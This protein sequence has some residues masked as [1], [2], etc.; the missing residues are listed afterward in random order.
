MAKQDL[1]QLLEQAAQ[2]LEKGGDLSQIEADQNGKTKEQKTSKKESINAQIK[3]SRMEANEAQEEA[4]E[5]EEGA[6]ISEAGTK[7]A[8]KVKKT[9]KG[10]A[11]T[12]SAKYVKTVE[13]VDKT[14]KYEISEAFE[15]AKK[16]TLT[17]FDGNIEIHIRLIGKSG[18]PEQ[19]RAMISYPH[20]TGKKVN[21]VILDE[22][23]IEEITKTGKAEAD[24]YLTTPA[25]MGK[26]AKLARILGPKGK[27]PNPKS[28][29]ITLDPAKTKAELEGGKSEFKTDSY[30]IVHQVMGKVSAK[31]E[32]LLANYKTLV[33]ALPMEKAVSISLSATMGPGIRVQK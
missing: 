13:L 23:T 24:I 2:T 18:K 10:K 28:G 19:V 26:V 31:P 15:L 11:K 33:A 12:R 25:E 32:E 17:K 4:V 8:K 1:D 5:S 22:K 21:V 20:L 30:G 3:K 27:M 9:K 6:Q 16:T 29:T 7:D 14:K